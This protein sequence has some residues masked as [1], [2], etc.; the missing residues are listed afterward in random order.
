M[1]HQIWWSI[2]TEKL[3]LK[4]IEVHW[5]LFTVTAMRKCRMSS[6]IKPPSNHLRVYWKKTSKPALLAFCDGNPP[7]TGGLPIQST[8]YADIVFIWW[9][10]HDYSDDI[11]RYPWSLVLISP[12]HYNDVIMTTMASQ[13][14]SLTVV[15]SQVW[16]IYW[17][18]KVIFPSCHLTYTRMHTITETSSLS[19]Y[20]VTRPQW[21]NG[22]T[23]ILPYFA[24][25]L[26]VLHWVI[27]KACVSDC[28]QIFLFTQKS[29][30]SL[31]PAGQYTCQWNE[32]LL[33][34]YQL[35][36]SPSPSCYIS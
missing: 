33:F 2:E 20:G 36:D 12:F 21:F 22:S 15:Y 34:G 29:F 14:T 32:S 6:T 18:S 16:P 13:I 35:L 3:K 10:H 28:N 7:V 25:W 11:Q 31:K 30:E 27:R 4:L 26:L 17:N 5:R 1:R 23:S 24:L 8:S 19:P 9:R